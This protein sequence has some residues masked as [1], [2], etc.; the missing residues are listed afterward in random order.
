LLPLRLKSEIG[1]AMFVQL[2]GEEATFR[3]THWNRSPRCRNGS[4]DQ[5]EEDETDMRPFHIS[6][7]QRMERLPRRQELDT[8]R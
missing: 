4:L 3:D 6:H 2:V 1:M 8:R 7:R 5:E